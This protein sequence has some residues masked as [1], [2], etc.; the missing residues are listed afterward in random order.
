LR[1]R[2]TSARTWCDVGWFVEVLSI[3]TGCGRCSTMD[4]R[5][6]THPQVRQPWRLLHEVQRMKKRHSVRKDTHRGLN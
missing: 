2:R 3:Q 4:R 6:G 5:E 1:F